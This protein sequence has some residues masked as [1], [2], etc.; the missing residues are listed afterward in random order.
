ME[1]HPN[2]MKKGLCPGY[3]SLLLTPWRNSRAFSLGIRESL[4]PETTLLYLGPQRRTVSSHFMLPIKRGP[5]CSCS[6]LTLH[7]SSEE[8]ILVHRNG[9]SVYQPYWTAQ[10]LSPLYFLGYYLFIAC[11]YNLSASSLSSRRFWMI[12]EKWAARTSKLSVSTPRTCS[13]NGYV[14]SG[15]RNNMTAIPQVIQP[16]IGN[17]P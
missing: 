15:P 4:L 14:T 8:S 11:L 6:L 3:G 12:L 16:Y 17:N 10:G 7:P 5:E 1:L 2:N 13:V 9:L